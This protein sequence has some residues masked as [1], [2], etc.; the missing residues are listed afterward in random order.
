MV[1]Y[2]HNQS[3]K[4]YWNRI[5]VSHNPH[6][7]II[8]HEI[9]HIIDHEKRGK[10]KHDKKLMRIVKSVWN[11]A[12][13]KNFWEEEIKRRTTPKPVKP[14]PTKKEVILKKIE[15]KVVSVWQQKK[16]SIQ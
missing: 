2:G 7:S 10:S 8:C 3:G 5:H 9:A 12:K 15:K 11:Y 14:E 1:L 6:R 4:A 16:K 13:R